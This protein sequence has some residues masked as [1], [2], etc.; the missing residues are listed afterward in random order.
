MTKQWTDLFGD[1]HFCDFQATQPV[2]P[3]GQ[4]KKNSKKKKA[5]KQ[6]T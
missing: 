5:T 3:L 2:I 6:R 1:K 4:I